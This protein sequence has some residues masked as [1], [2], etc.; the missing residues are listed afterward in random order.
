MF[1][2]LSC[3]LQANNQNKKKKIRNRS[4]EIFS[5]YEEKGQ[6]FLTRGVHTNGQEKHKDPNGEGERRNKHQSVV[7]GI[8]GGMGEI[9]EDFHISVIFKLLQTIQF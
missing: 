2:K 6:L 3:D 8:L 4:G 7:V 1:T 5:K 9:T